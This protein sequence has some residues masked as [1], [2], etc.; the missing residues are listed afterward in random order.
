MSMALVVDCRSRDLRVFFASVTEAANRGLVLRFGAD[1]GRLEDLSGGEIPQDVIVLGS[2]A[3]R[4]SAGFARVERPVGYHARWMAGGAGL[5]REERDGLRPMFARVGGTIPAVVIVGGCELAKVSTHQNSN[6]ATAA[7]AVAGL[8]LRAEMRG[9]VVVLEGQSDVVRGWAFKPT[10]PQNGLGG[11][12]P[13]EHRQD[14]FAG[15][16]PKVVQ[17][18]VERDEFIE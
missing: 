9:E 18:I 17:T 16:Q 14:V 12:F 15:M 1:L 11:K 2:Y 10:L 13:A 8:R 5:D 7:A 3:A 6:P 4:G